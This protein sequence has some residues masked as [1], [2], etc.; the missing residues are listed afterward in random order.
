MT[1][2]TGTIRVSRRIEIPCRQ[3][4]LR[5]LKSFRPF[6][7]DELK[8]IEKFKI[9]EVRIAPGQTILAEGENSPHLY[10]MLSGWAIKHKSLDDGRRQIVNYALP[11]DLLGLQA[12][13]FDKMQHSAEALT[14]V[15][16]CAFDK[17]KI[18][19]LYQNHHGLGF[20][21]TWL[22]AREKSILA[23]FLVTVGQRRARERIAFLLLFLYRRARSVGLVRRNTVTFPFNQE[24]FADTIGFSL[25]HTNKSLNRMRKMDMFEW[26]GHTFRMI[27]EDA[28]H[29][30]AGSPVQIAGLRPFI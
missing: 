15:V 12:A 1:I 22:A 24:H 17:D 30:Y 8:F 21:I 6:T 2:T 27:D 9:G 25:V 28:L 29:D 19:S 4:P 20:D 16:L 18:W 3:C 10:T 13:L 11:G 5:E 14:D 23:D 7:P 26:T